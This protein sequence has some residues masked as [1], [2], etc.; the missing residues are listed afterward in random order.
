MRLVTSEALAGAATPLLR[1]ALAELVEDEKD[2][3][4]IHQL[5]REEEVRLA[6][7]WREI[8]VQIT[9]LASALIVLLGE[10]EV[11]E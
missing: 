2:D 7:R 3:L 11:S 5:P 1:L 9:A 4:I 6:R 10:G 8:G